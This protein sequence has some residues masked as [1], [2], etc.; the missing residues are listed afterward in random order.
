MLQV[1]QLRRPSQQ[2]PA[3]LECRGR[4]PWR[5]RVKMISSLTIAACGATTAGRPHS[6]RHWCQ[7]KNGSEAVGEIRMNP[8]IPNE[9]LRI[10][11]AGSMRPRQ[12]EPV[13]RNKPVADRARGCHWYPELCPYPSIPTS[14]ESGHA[15]LS[16]RRSVRRTRHEG[17]AR[18]R[19]PPRCGSAPV[20][21]GENGSMQYTLHSQQG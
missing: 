9:S 11:T 5:A 3:G 6:L 2:Y 12:V 15:V 1:L 13:P 17:C 21:L 4:S 19:L 20:P 8:V 10:A 14:L 18:S 7:P 16:W